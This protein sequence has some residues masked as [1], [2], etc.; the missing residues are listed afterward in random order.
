[1]YVYLPNGIILFYNNCHK[2]LNVVNEDLT[3]ID[4][5]K[6][7]VRHM[8]CFFNNIKTICVKPN[9]FRLDCDMFVDVK[10]INNE[11]LTIIFW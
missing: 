1:M 4:T 2:V 6:Y 9:I 8:F 3:D 7:D 10:N 5:L 11:E